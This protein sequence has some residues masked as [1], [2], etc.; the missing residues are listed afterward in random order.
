MV[1]FFLKA[2]LF[3]LFPLKTIAQTVPYLIYGIALFGIL[4]NLMVF[5]DITICKNNIIF[6]RILKK[7]CNCTNNIKMRNNIISTVKD[8]KLFLFIF[9]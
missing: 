2:K 6:T 4:H 3:L 1:F 5:T 7:L 9:N 8:E